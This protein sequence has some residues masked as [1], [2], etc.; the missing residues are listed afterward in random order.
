LRYESKAPIAKD[1]LSQSDPSSETRIP[2]PSPQ[3]K[4]LILVLSGNERIQGVVSS[5][6][7]RETFQTAAYT[8]NYVSLY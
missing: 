3:Q 6:S 8:K 2:N 7:S 1:P 5:L 4:L